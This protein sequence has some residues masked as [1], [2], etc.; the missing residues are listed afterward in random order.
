LLLAATLFLGASGAAL[1]AESE[2][3]AITPDELPRPKA[4]PHRGLKVAALGGIEGYTSAL[5]P[6]VNPGPAWGVVLNSQPTNLF[7]LELVYSGARNGLTEPGSSGGQVVRNG[8]NIHLKLTL[9]P[10]AAE[11]YLY[12]GFGVSF[13]NVSGAD[14]DFQD[15]AFGQLSLGTGVAFH[16]GDFTAGGRLGFDL[17]FNEAFATGESG[18]LWNGRLEVGAVF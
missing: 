18:N 11:P 5:A 3:G 9:Q 7:G 12:G 6:L 15:D 16:M 8:A 14:E 10:K 4:P 13:A 2:Q 17:L 1:G